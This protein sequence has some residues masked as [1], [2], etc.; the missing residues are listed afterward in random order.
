MAAQSSIQAELISR[1]SKLSDIIQTNECEAGL[2]Y[3]NQEHSANFRYL[4]NFVPTM[5]DMW[6]VISN[7]GEMECVCTFHWEL[8]EAR[9]RSGFHEWYGQIDPLPRVIQLLEAGQP[10]RLAVVGR[11]RLPVGLFEQLRTR[12]IDTEFIDIGVQF[13]I[14]RRCKSPTEIALLRHAVSITDRAMQGIREKLQPGMTEHSIAAELLYDFQSQGI[15]RLAFSPLVVSGVDNPVIARETTGRQIQI[16]DPVMIDIGAEYEGYQADLTRTFVLGRASQTQERAW[17]VVCEAY[18]AVLEITRPGMPCRQ[19][20]TKAA[21]ILEDAGYPMLHR[22]GHGIGLA[23]SFEWPSL[24]TE[25]DPLE[26]GM[27]IAI[28]PAVY[29]AGVGSMKLED[30]LVITETGCE[31]LSRCSQDLLVEI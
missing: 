7:S 26:P 21:S 10:K 20:H 29:A 17:Q 18:Q 14:L 16:G 28:E 8:G 31:V 3:G 12:F 25:T 4:T 15:S 9:Q 24:D 1:R 6:G 23:T 30:S 13:S 2:V 5:G 11:D 27:T 19:L 22:I